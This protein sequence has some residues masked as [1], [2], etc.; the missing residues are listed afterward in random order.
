MTG[1]DDD[2]LSTPDRTL[3]ILVADEDTATLQDLSDL[4]RGLG[5]DVTQFAISVQEAA[6][7]VAA[8]DPDV[9]VVRLDAD[10]QHALALISEISECCLL[11]TSDA[12][13]E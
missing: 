3:R 1:D 13:D 4:L 6:Q 7:V 10:D 11:Y 9:A 8:E 5:H 2:D 12:A